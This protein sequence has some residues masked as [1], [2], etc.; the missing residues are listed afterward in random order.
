M[1]WQDAFLIAGGLAAGF[2]SG[3]IGIG[4]GLLFV[5]TM[6]IG[7][8]LSQKVAQG[9]SL[10]AVVPTAIVGG[11]THIRQGNVQ[12]EPALWMGGG[13]V[14]GAVVGALIAIEVPGPL[15]ARV[16][17]AF[18]LFSAYRLVLQ[19]YRARKSAVA[20]STSEGGATFS[21]KR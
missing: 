9:T 17:G 6:T 14:V 1:S 16:W 5:P 19:A 7:A 8:G 2:L 3:T 13:G 11:V 18:L 15:L 12:L 4:G 21:P 20:P 10:V